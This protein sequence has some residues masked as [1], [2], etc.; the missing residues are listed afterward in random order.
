[1]HI[2][3]IKMYAEIKFTQLLI[4]YNKLASKDATQLWMWSSMFQ[5]QPLFQLKKS[6]QHSHDD[7]KPKNCRSLR[8]RLINFKLKVNVLQ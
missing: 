1:M 6:L 2:M 3:L 7:D 8:L 4:V 5:N